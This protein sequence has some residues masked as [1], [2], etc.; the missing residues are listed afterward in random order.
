MKYFK[1]LSEYISLKTDEGESL[2]KK[3]LD[4]ISFVGEDTCL[5]A[6][7]NPDRYKLRSYD[8]KQMIFPFGCNASQKLAVRNA[9]ENSMS[10]IEG[11]PGTGKTQTILNI[12][13]NILFQGKTVAVVSNNNSATI[14][15]LEKLEKYGLDFIAAYLGNSENKKNFI[16]NQSVDIERIESVDKD[17]YS[18]LLIYENELSSNIDDMLDKNNTLAQNRQNIKAFEFEMKRYDKYY[19]D[20]FYDVV[21]I[22]LKEGI[23]SDRLMKLWVKFIQSSDVVDKDKIPFLKRLYYSF[24]LGRRNYKFFGQPVERVVSVL[25]KEFYKR[26]HAELSNEIIEL[27]KAL[28]RY[29]FTEKLDELSD[30]NTKN[31]A[32]KQI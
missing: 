7:L 16:E 25:Q 24:I 6:Y 28:E 30:E 5:A 1:E 11:P 13:A 27:E 26:K 14:N 21:D 17:E 4:V 2:M 32:C 15:V 10:I 23:S 9:M 29:N 31:Q 8:E 18:E 19:K 12:I 20:T 22:Q 3:K